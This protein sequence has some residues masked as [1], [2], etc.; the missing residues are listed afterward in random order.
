MAVA[1]TAVGAKPARA[2]MG[3]A[4]VPLLGLMVFINYVDRGNFGTAAPLIKDELHLSAGRI[5]VLTSAFFWSYT[6]CQL[7]AGWLTER[8][9]PYRVLAAGLALWA[10]ATAASGLVTGFAA[11]LVLRVV[12]GLGESAAFPCSSKLIGQ[13]LP[14]HQLG[15]ANSIILVGTSLG[16][17]FGVFAGGLIMSRVGW[18][19]SFIMFGLASLLWLGPWLMATRASRVA[20]DAARAAD[21]LAPSFLEIIG[22]REAWGAGLGHFALNYAF[23][24]VVSW[25]PLYLVKARGF[26]MAHMGVLSG[27]IYLV[28][29]ASLIVLGWANDRLIAAGRPVELVRKGFIATGFLIVAASFMVTSMAGPTIAIAA[30]FVAGFGFG[31]IGPSNYAL[32]QTL[33]GP[34]AAGKWMGFQNG[35]GNVAGIV[36][37][38]ITGWIVDKTGSFSSAFVVAAGMATVGILCWCVIVRRVEPLVWKAA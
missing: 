18:R 10:L 11:L 7:L 34:H 25:L 26:S 14:P 6:P 38:L 30:L 37:P 23:Y 36:C 1:D 29:A 33:A 32:G 2:A 22:R 24:F 12:L 3:A 28:Y 35:V 27:E 31:F 16:P 5:G 13:H 4:V 20:A 17:A 8:F 9:S 21:P 19:P 15:A